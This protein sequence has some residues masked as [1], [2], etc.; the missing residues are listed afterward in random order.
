MNL[1]AGVEFEDEASLSKKVAN[2][3][4]YE[5]QLEDGGHSIGLQR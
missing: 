4:T 3:M 1:T 5:C 2:T